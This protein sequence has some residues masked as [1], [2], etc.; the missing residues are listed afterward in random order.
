ME[1][2]RKRGRQDTMRTVPGVAVGPR[3]ST[4]PCYLLLASPYKVQSSVY[5]R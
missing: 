3:L 4:C 1:A 5:T 2:N